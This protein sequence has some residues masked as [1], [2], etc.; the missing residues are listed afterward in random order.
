MAWLV[1]I[2]EWATGAGKRNLA[3]PIALECSCIRVYLVYENFPGK[4][5]RHFLDIA[6]FGMGKPEFLSN[7]GP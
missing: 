5:K 4:K 3:K 7:S 1:N 2:C 6:I